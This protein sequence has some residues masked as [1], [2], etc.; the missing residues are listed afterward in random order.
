MGQYSLRDGSESDGGRL[1]F[2]GV[3]PCPGQV[4]HVGGAR[5][6]SQ[7]ALAHSV[8]LISG[9]KLGRGRGGEGEGRGGGA[10]AGKF[11]SPEEGG[12]GLGS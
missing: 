7:P 5:V 4:L 6:F 11:A 1:V 9:S 2:S 12:L 3:F 8:I 10:L